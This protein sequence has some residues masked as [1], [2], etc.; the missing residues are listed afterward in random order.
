MTFSFSV[1]SK[2]T[3]LDTAPS[4]V[5]SML[6]PVW[7]FPSACPSAWICT[8]IRSDIAYPEASS[9]ALVIFMPVETCFSDFDS[10]F[11]FLFNVFSVFVACMLFFTTIGM[12]K[13]SLYLSMQAQSDCRM[14]AKPSPCMIYIVKKTRSLKQIF[15]QTPY[16]RKI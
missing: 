10:A 3:E 9:C 8:R 15:L 4:A 1:F 12:A 5:F 7:A 2:S 11:S 6:F 13:T 14:E 16:P